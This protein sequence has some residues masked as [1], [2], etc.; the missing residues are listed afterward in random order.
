MYVKTDTILDKILAQKV[1]EVATRQTKMPL[2]KVQ[3]LARVACVPR[4]FDQALRA[5]EHVALIAEV[6]KASPSKGVLIENFDP[7][8]IG[9]TYSDN[10][11]SAISVLT[12][13]PFFMG[14]LAYLNAVRG[15]VRVPVLRKDFIIDPYQVY[16]TRA[17]ETD[18]LLLIVAALDDAQ[19][20]DLHTLTNELGMSALVEV[21]DEAEVERALKIGA[22]IIGVNNRDLKTFDMDLGTT[23]RLAKLLP[24]EVILVAE[25]G[26]H[27][28]EDVANMASVGAH[29]VLVGE[30]LVKSGDIASAVRQ[31]SSVAR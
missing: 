5:G 7:V 12:D 21:H 19:L 16:E 20:A 25:S 4:H 30:S 28:P 3:N 14:D 22:T 31:L 26:I 15:N 18:A 2:K 13:T 10:G 8:A 23:A 29:A 11:A 27:T 6:K 24:K 9:K 17:E 1:D